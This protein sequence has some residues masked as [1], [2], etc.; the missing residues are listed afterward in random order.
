[1]ADAPSANPSP[2]WS[3]WTWRSA[4]C[5]SRRGEGAGRTMRICIVGCGAIGSLF[6]AHLARLAEVEVWAFDVAGDR[7]QAVNAG[8][9]SVTGG[10]RFAVSRVEL[11]WPAGPA[12]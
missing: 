11:S 2:R 5:G 4:T 12:R 3:R 1:M 6:A 9:L 8:G 10:A 7:V